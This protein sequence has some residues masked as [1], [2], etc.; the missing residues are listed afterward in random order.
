MTIRIYMSDL[1][2]KI[3]SPCK[4]LTMS[5]SRNPTGYGPRK[6]QVFDEDEAKYELCMGSKVF[7]V[8][9]SSKT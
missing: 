4:S 7:S 1:I 3:Y 5:T 9:A 6:G 8:Y 2:I